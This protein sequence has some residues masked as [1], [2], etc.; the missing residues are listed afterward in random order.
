MRSSLNASARTLA[1]V[2]SLVAFG[3][4]ECRAGD[5]EGEATITVVRRD[6]EVFNGTHIYINGSKVGSVSQSSTETFTF[7]PKKNGQNE[8]YV[9]KTEFGRFVENSKKYPFT[10]GKNGKVTFSFSYGSSSSGILTVKEK[11]EIDGKPNY[12]L[13]DVKFD[14]K[15]ATKVIGE[16]EILETPPGVE[17]EY[18]LSRTIE[19]SVTFSEAMSLELS[20]KVDFK[21]VGAEVKAKIE[22]QE[23]Q[24]FK[25]SETIRRNVK[26]NGTNSPKVKVT[27]VAT[28]RTGTATVYV[29]DVEKKIPFSF[30]TAL[31]PKLAIVK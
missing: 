21:V 31:Q 23:S 3:A 22:R 17:Q 2:V 16:P 9:T 18:E 20:G 12:R 25:A 30:Q 7:A 13:A 8:M 27:W 11:G 29:N 24:T 4:A 5:T 1:A 10:V 15:P 19:R 6:I 26:V 28:Y 14:G